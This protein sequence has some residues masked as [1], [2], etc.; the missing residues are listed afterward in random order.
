MRMCACVGT[1]CEE[2]HAWDNAGPVFITM[3]SPE[4]SD[5]LA[6]HVWS[7][8]N[9]GGKQLQKLYVFRNVRLPNGKRTTLKL[10]RAVTG[11]MGTA[12]VDHR[13]GVG[14]DNRRHNLR[15][16]A[17]H[18]QNAMNRRKISGQ[19]SSRFKGV[20]WHK[21]CQLW[22]AHITIERKLTFLG[23][24]D[25]EEDAARAYDAAALRHFGEFALLNFPEEATHAA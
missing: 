3:V 19:R 23:C 8:H 10:H 6:A 21:R 12:L 16:G 24:Y 2:Q 18:A 25:R 1:A 7:A 11:A 15:P 4:D 22:Q 5:L 13:S 17:T 14:L 20:S 9:E